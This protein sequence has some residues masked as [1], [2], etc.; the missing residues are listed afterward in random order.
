MSPET[1]PISPLADITGYLDAHP[2]FF[3]QRPE[4]LSRLILPHVT[5]GNVA[6]LIEYQVSKL[7]EEL[8]ELHHGISRR[9]YDA[10][11]HRRL[12]A[13]IHALCLKILAAQ[14]L[15]DLHKMLRRDLKSCYSA[16]KV[17]LLIFARARSGTHQEGLKLHDPGSSLCFMFAELFH[18]GKPLCGSLQEEHLRAL[19]GAN[20]E[21]I[22]STVLLPYA[23][24]GWREL[25][26]LGS[27][28]ENRY[29]HGLELE[30]LFFLNNM[31]NSVI[32]KSLKE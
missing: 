4:L 32:R 31:L 12:I 1:T 13:E 6:S 30:L 18:R 27:S 14:S 5:G 11:L 29:S 3:V 16:D 8:D 26:V 17:L 25:L 9:E 21:E 23:G 7:R 20:C 24:A 15:Q 22:K 2:D 19:F 28:T 10:A